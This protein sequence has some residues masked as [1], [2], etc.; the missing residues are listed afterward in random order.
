MRAV[1]NSKNGQV[2][3]E[4][5]FKFSQN[6]DRLTA[7]YSGGKIEY[8]QIIGWIDDDGVIDMLYH[9]MD[10]DGEIYAGHSVTTPEIL[11]NG[12]L[13]LHE[14]WEWT[15]GKIGQGSSVLEEI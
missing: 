14:A 4:T 1:S 15:Y 13:R 11:P 9:H 3:S 12:K 5:I 8:G 6:H 7:S 10:R 2:S